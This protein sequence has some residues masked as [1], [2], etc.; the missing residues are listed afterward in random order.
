M[1]LTLISLIAFL[2][3]VTGGLSL[4]MFF[5]KKKGDKDWSAWANLISAAGTVVIGVATIFVMFQEN[6]IQTR[7]AKM[8]E[9]EHQPIIV[10]KEVAEESVGSDIFDYAEF[11]IYNYGAMVKSIEKVSAD[12]FIRIGYNIGDKRR[13]TYAPLEDYYF[14][15][16]KTGALQGD[17]AHSYGSFKNHNNYTYASRLY[18]ASSSRYDNLAL[19][20]ELVKTYKIEYIDIYGVHKA[21]CFI[22]E[23]ETSGDNYQSIHDRAYNDFGGD[24]FKLGDV[25][26]DDIIDY[27]E[28]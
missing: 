7:L 15:Y 21:I 1:Y 10:V 23:S 9:A 25:T 5:E 26:I 8:E 18:N 28:K 19:Y 4:R 27:L 16:Y 24:S 12:V 13:D 2:V 11:Y 3:V 14:R 6:S 20:T 17:I 22:G